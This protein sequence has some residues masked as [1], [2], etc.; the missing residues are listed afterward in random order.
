M[1][2]PLTSR[3]SRVLLACLLILALGVVAATPAS[4][5][6]P[7]A[8]QDF[9][10]R[11]NQ[12]RTSRSL[13]A[14]TVCGGIVDVARAW[15]DKRAATSN[16]VGHNPSYTSQIPSGWT[17]AAENVAWGSGTSATVAVL[18][19]SLMDSAG[20]RANILGDFTHIGVGVTVV[21]NQMY[22]TQ[23]FGKYASG[24][25]GATTSIALTVTKGTYDNGTKSKATLSW[26]GATGSNVDVWRN[27]AKLLTT[28]NDGAHVDKFGVKLAAG[29]VRS[30][31]VCRAGTTT[32][33]PTRSVTF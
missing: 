13:K 29:T 2:S 21:S 8:E 3:L 25:G 6:L 33:S 17:R 27:G 11:I 1:T 23:N 26:S 30:Y 31:K 4:A 32:C 28:A 7:S 9:V 20:H 10:T 18:H 15:S 14:L 5:A 19:K 16:H 24:C 22:V 12:E